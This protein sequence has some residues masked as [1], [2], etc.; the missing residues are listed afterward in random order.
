MARLTYAALM[1]VDGYVADPSGGF[2][3]AMPDET[4]HAFINDLERSVG[5]HLYG[6]RMY[7]VMA[8][9]E[10]MSAPD[11]PA[12]MDYADIWRAADKI[13]YSSTLTATTT[14]R[15][16]LER[17]FD[18]DQVRQLKLQA[19]ADLSIG[20]PTLAAH[21]LRAGIVDDVHL[22]VA[23]C[24]VGGGLRAFPHGL[25]AGFGLRDHRS[26]GNGMVYQHY[27]VTGS[28]RGRSL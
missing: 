1:S 10:T 8:A 4:V 22:F 14:A 15:T 18:P 7:E 25:T 20:G 21:A 23:P 13:V 2:D 11:S 28:L 6:R 3:W 27:A 19:T 24:L 12:M 9:W 17:S 26:F 5:I 16:R